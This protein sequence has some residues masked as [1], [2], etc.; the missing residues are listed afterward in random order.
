MSTVASLIRNEFQKTWRSR[1][2]V[3]VVLGGLFVL[4]A[5]G[6][7]AYYVHLENRWTPPAPVAWQSQLRDQIASNQQEIVN[8]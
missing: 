7:Y 8:L 5:G 6:L 4:I 1:W 2:I 3:F